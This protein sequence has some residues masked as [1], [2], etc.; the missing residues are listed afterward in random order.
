MEQK[1]IQQIIK[2]ELSKVSR[3]SFWLGMILGLLGGLALS[4]ELAMGRVTGRLSFR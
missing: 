1:Q 4:F 3:Q 2:R